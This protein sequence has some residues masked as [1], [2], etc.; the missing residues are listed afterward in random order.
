MKKLNEQERRFLAL[1][2]KAIQKYA[3]LQR[4]EAHVNADKL[5]TARQSVR[6]KYQD[7]AKKKLEE[8]LGE[9]YSLL[10]RMKSRGQVE[11]MLQGKNNSISRCSRK[12]HTEKQD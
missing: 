11:K 7:T 4:Q 10:W 2:K 6:A 9:R 5:N 1:S 12:E 8:T 3:D